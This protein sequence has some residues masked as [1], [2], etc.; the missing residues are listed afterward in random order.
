[1]IVTV[2]PAVIE[3]LSRMM[4]VP[5]VP[6]VSPVMMSVPPDAVLIRAAAAVPELSALASE[7]ASA[8]SM[9]RM[10]LA[11]A[12]AIG[13]V[14]ANV[15]RI[16]AMPADPI[17]NTAVAPAAVVTASSRAFFTAVV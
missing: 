1:V 10:P 4:S 14:S 5:D 17:S 15:A 6:T 7:I 2:W 13:F 3:T 11:A 16:E 9:V 8:Q 12:G